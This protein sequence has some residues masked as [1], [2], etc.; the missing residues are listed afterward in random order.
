VT[1]RD[2]SQIEVHSDRI[3][4]RTSR[5]QRRTGWGGKRRHRRPRIPRRFAQLLLRSVDFPLLFAPTGQTMRSY[6]ASIP[7]GPVQP[8][9]ALRIFIS[10]EQSLT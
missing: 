3:L 8:S 10:F 9:F 1:C 5:G 2:T 6:A 7:S 4:A